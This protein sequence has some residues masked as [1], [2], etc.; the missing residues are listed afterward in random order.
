LRE[1]GGRELGLFATE[2]SPNNFPRLPLR[3]TE[4]VFVWFLGFADVEA[5]HAHMTAL[6]KN[7]RWGRDTYPALLERLQ[8]RPQILRLAP[9]S[10]SQLR[11]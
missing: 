10:R 9:T 5:Y 11:G 2:H 6:G 3:D 4:T 8:T 7:A 1:A